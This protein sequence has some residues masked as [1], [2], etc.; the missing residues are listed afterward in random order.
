MFMN[1]VVGLAELAFW[2]AAFTRE[3]EVPEG[4]MVLVEPQTQTRFL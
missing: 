1:T 3:P 4:N 2:L